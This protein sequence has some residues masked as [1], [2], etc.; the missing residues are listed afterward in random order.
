MARSERSNFAAGWCFVLPALMVIFQAARNGGLIQVPLGAGTIAAAG[1]FLVN[2]LKCA[3]GFCVAVLAVHTIS[4]VSLATKIGVSST[5]QTFKGFVALATVGNV[6]AIATLLR[7][8]R[9]S[10]EA[11]AD[12]GVDERG[13]GIE[14]D[15]SRRE[16]DG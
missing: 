1:L 10:V 2:D 4:I 5:A 3:R 9:T 13:G 14:S 6:I 7:G 8:D 11:S 12:D 15:L 16:Q